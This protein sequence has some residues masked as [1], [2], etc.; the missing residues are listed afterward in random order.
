[1]PRAL[2]AGGCEGRVMGSIMDEAKRKT[3]R[4]V[5]AAGSAPPSPRALATSLDQ[6]AGTLS[7]VTEELQLGVPRQML[8]TSTRLLRQASSL[9]EDESIDVLVKKAHKQMKQRPA[10]TLV[11]LLGVGFVA[12]RLARM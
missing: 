9:L 4:A 12:G 1:M 8:E 7:H 10:L 11:G 6:A 5:R 3:R 2:R